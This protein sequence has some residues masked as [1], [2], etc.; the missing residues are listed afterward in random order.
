MDFLSNK[1]NSKSTKKLQKIKNYEEEYNLL[2]ITFNH[3]VKENESLKV[4]LSDLKTTVKLN[5]DVLKDYIETITNK[6]KAVEKMSC[7]ID[8]LTDRL[9]SLEETLRQ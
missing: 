2:K 3:I 8:T 9:Y 7:T 1:L 6:D 5:K 4:Q